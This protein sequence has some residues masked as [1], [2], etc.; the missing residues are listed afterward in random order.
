M[1]AS[2]RSLAITRHP[3]RSNPHES[4]RRRVHLWSCNHPRL[5]VHPRPLIDGRAVAAGDSRPRSRGA[6]GLDH[7]RVRSRRRRRV[8]GSGRWPRFARAATP[9]TSCRL[10]TGLHNH[11][12]TGWTA[13]GEARAEVLEQP[14]Y[15]CGGLFAPPTR[16]SFACS[17]RII[18]GEPLTGMSAPDPV[19]G[20]LAF[21]SSPGRALVTIS[22]A[23]SGPSAGSGSR[24]HS[25]RTARSARSAMH[26]RPGTGCGSPGSWRGATLARRYGEFMCTAYSVAPL[27]FTTGHQ[28]SSRM[29]VSIARRGSQGPG[30]RRT[31]YLTWRRSSSPVSCSRAPVA[32]NARAGVRQPL[33]RAEG[34]V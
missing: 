24:L 15:R 11:A 21:G 2:R 20:R 30:V 16:G 14:E 27:K 18:W 29:A 25:W 33:R 32:P 34:S 26:P 1:A 22:R 3:D 31:A 5:V 9:R 17:S 23:R 10:D 4:P 12:P 7:P 28:R 13:S 19:I 6:P 8:L